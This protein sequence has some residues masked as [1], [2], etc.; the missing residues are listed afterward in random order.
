MSRATFRHERVPKAGENR[1]TANSLQNAYFHFAREF[2]VLNGRDHSDDPR[3]GG[4]KPNRIN[5]LG[6]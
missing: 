5:R 4:Y 2:Y 3:R 6:Q 1:V